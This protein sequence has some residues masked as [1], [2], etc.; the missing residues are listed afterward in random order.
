MP[1]SDCL[2][3]EPSSITQ[4]NSAN[5]N[6]AGHVLNLDRACREN[7]DLKPCLAIT[8]FFFFFF[9]CCFIII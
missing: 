4:A 8:F 9:F 7:L 3:I 1:S 6:R 5:P 2:I